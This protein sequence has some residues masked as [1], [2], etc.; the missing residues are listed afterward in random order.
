VRLTASVPEFA[1]NAGV[2]RLGLNWFILLAVYH[3][4]GMTNRTRA[5]NAASVPTP[6]G[7]ARAQFNLFSQMFRVNS[8]PKFSVSMPILPL[9]R[10]KAGSLSIRIETR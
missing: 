4:C 5:T 9:G 6:I 3:V 1:A 7:I 8:S 2:R 10:K